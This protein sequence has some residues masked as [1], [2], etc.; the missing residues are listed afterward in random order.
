MPHATVPAHAQGLDN[1]RFLE[2]DPAEIAFDY[3]FDAVVGRLILMYY[4]DPVEAV[5]KLARHLRP[6]GLIVFQEFDYGGVRC[7]P[8]LPL[9][10]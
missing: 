2:G 7:R 6:G 8:H 5:R 9:C 4:P 10:E 3:P 1:V